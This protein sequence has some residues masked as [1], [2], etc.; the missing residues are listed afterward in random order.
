MSHVSYG[1]VGNH[2]ELEQANRIEPE[3][4]YILMRMDK[5]MIWFA[6]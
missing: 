1:P 6:D 3:A 5:L 2:L 4:L